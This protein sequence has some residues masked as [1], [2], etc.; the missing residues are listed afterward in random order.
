MIARRLFKVI[1]EWK[2]KAISLRTRYQETRR[3]LK[4]SS[5]GEIVKDLQ[6]RL[7]AC[8]SRNAPPA[9]QQQQNHCPQLGN[10]LKAIADLQARLDTCHGGRTTA[11]AG[12]TEDCQTRKSSCPTIFNVCTFRLIWKM[13][14]TSQQSSRPQKKSWPTRRNNGRT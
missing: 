13:M 7:E 3:K 9:G 4:Q 6:A 11:P 14:L 8:E 12:S 2:D 5:E 10:L 1:R